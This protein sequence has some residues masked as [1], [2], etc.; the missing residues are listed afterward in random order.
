MVGFPQEAE[1]TRSGRYKPGQDAEQGSFPGT[2]GA[3]QTQNGTGWDLKMDIVKGHY[4]A[5]SPGKG[6]CGY[7]RCLRCGFRPACR[8]GQFPVS[9]FY[10]LVNR[11]SGRQSLPQPDP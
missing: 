10:S 11:L 9:L 7:R 2:V 5:K 3:Q 6:R 8:P 4:P 1:E